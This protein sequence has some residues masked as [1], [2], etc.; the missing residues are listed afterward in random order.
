MGFI[1]SIESIVNACILAGYLVFK[2]F[3]EYGNAFLH[4]QRVVQQQLFS[5]QLHSLLFTVTL[6]AESYTMLILKFVCFPYFCQLDCHKHRP[7]SN[8]LLSF[9]I[10][11][12]C[13]YIVYRDA[14]QYVFK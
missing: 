6:T 13:V 7:I 1:S 2:S 12:Y 9:K 14:I 11:D 8:M 4:I 10:R 5:E 3:I